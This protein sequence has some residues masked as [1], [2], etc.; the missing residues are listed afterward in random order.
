MNKNMK[1]KNQIYLIIKGVALKKKGDEI[2][3]SSDGP[4]NRIV[5]IRLKVNNLY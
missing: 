3:T 1:G 4:L 2:R 5:E